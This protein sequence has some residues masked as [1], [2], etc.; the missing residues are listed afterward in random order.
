MK[1]ICIDFDGVIHQYSQGWKDGSIYDNP[2]NNAFETINLLVEQGYSVVIFSTR[3]PYQIKKWLVRFSN[4]LLYM[5]QSEFM[6]RYYPFQEIDQTIIEN[7]YSNKRLQHK[8]KVIPFWKKFWNSSTIGI[9]R[10]KL[11]A[12]IY[13]DDRALKFEGNWSNTLEQIKSFKTYQ[14]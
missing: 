6:D 12:T 11:P 4:Q 7:E 9:T 13:V 8:V 3:S 5:S 2:V 10:R 1:T 14:E